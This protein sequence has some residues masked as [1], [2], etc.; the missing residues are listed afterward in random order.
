MKNHLISKPV[1]Q[2]RMIY[3]S[4]KDS[5]HILNPTAQMVLELHDKG[6]DE[7]GIARELGT[8]FE[9]APGHDVLKD[10]GQCLASLKEAGMID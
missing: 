6:L 10:V 2:D 8:L 9:F 5:V 3:D 1:G 4:E 7:A